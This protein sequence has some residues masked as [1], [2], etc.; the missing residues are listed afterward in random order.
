MD[1]DRKN[2]AA[3]CT[4]ITDSL[5]FPKEMYIQNGEFVPGTFYPTL[6]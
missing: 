1:M 6:A 2:I 5:S 3:M 4:F